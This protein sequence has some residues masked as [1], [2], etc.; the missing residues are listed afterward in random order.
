MDINLVQIIFLVIVTGIVGY[1]GG[2][3]GMPLGPVRLSSLAE[4]ANLITLQ[5]KALSLPCVEP[6]IT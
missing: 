4:E 3:V 1:I 2:L 5:S 6:E